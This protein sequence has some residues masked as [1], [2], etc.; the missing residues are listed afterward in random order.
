M[1]ITK[2][3]READS[4]TTKA[5]KIKIK[6]LIQSYFQI[7]SLLMKENSI[8]HVLKEP[9]SRNSFMFNVFNFKH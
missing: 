9:Y 7:V 6:S 8:S 3:G 2:Y 1:T 4:L 5:M